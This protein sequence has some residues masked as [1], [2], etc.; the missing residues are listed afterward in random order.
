LRPVDSS[1]Q[2]AEEPFQP[3]R[4]I[5]PFALVPFQSVIIFVSFGFDLRRH[6]VEA[7]SRTV[8][9]L[10][11][12]IGDGA[13]NPSISVLKWMDGHEPK[14]GDPRFEY[15]VNAVAVS[16]HSRKRAISA[17]RR[18]AS[19]ASKC[20]PARKSK[21]AY[22]RASF[23][24]SLRTQSR[25]QPLSPVAARCTGGDPAPLRQMNWWIWLS[26]VFAVEYRFPLTRLCARAIHHPF[27]RDSG[28]ILRGT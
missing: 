19:G 8:S 1:A 14:M 11:H 16:N 20:S 10:K 18:W 23:S 25:P 22:W 7:I 5:E 2:A 9:A 15:G 17:S 13:G 21:G 4:D 26:R 6:T 27:A 28:S 12:H 24:I 3:R